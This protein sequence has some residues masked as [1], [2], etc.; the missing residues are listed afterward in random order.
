[1][2]K[3]SIMYPAGENTRFDMDYYRKHHMPMV[4]RVL[5]A[6]CKGFAIDRGLG[7]DAPGSPPTYVA[8]GHLLF[9][10]VEEFQIAVTP[11]IADITA[12]IVNYTTAKP[13][14]QISEVVV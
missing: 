5:G 1:M 9:D 12:D 10:S 11:H 7:G 14:I 3:V 4:Q 2:I 13:I 8:M 6:A